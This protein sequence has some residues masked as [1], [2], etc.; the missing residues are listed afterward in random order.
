MP[1]SGRNVT[2]PLGS[3]LRSGNQEGRLGGPA[4]D[5]AAKNQG[6]PAYYWQKAFG[7]ANYIPP[8]Q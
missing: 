5:Y 7:K 2:K 6:W 4:E 8:R 3:S 1:E